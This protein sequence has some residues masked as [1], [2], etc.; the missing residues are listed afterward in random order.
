[1]GRT[2]MMIGGA[3]LIALGVLFTL[4]G[5]GYVG[6]SAMSGSTTWAVLGPLIALVGVVLSVVGARKSR[7]R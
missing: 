6:G 5:L 1:M 2:G 3:V 4:Q 7:T